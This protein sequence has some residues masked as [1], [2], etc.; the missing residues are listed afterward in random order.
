[1]ESSY[2]RNAR[3]SLCCSTTQQR[4]VLSGYISDSRP[5]Y[6]WRPSAEVELVVSSVVALSTKAEGG[7]DWRCW[8][9]EQPDTIY[10]W[11]TTTATPIPPPPRH[12]ERDAGLCAPSTQCPRTPRGFKMQKYTIFPQ[13]ATKR[14]KEDGISVLQCGFCDIIS[15][16]AEINQT[17]SI[18]LQHGCESAAFP[19]NLQ[20][21]H[22]GRRGVQRK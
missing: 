5:A 13:L 7:G 6:P 17:R 9:E 11:R 8:E 12:R 14:R 19:L 3:P 10:V 22:S 18:S 16:S 2:S 1:V 21:G 4:G 20:H 15:Y